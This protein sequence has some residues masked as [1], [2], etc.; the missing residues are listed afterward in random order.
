MIIVESLV[1]GGAPCQ[2]S[3]GKA[4]AGSS[5]RKRSGGGP[6]GLTDVLATLGFHY[7]VDAL[8]W[9][10]TDLLVEPMPG[11]SNHRI[12]PPA[13]SRSGREEGCCGSDAAPPGDV[14]R[15]FADNALRHQRTPGQSAPLAAG[16]D[17]RYR[18]PR[19][20]GR[21]T[22]SFRPPRSAR[23]VMAWSGPCLV[24]YR[25]LRRLLET[26]I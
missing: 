14:K 1:R 10:L 11:R 20:S 12:L 19:S 15:R 5:S 6:A 22:R 13:R 25:V 21:P 7:R 23:P 17:A 26:G 3:P 24:R 18:L 9:A 8:V 2:R 16:G 4:C